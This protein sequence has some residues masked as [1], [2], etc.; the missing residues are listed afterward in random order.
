MLPCPISCSIHPWMRA[1][2]VLRASPYMA[3]TDS[4]GRFQIRNLPV[5][6]HTFRVWHE[7]VGYVRD[8]A[9]G[10]F[11]TD[12]RGRLVVKV[13]EGVKVFPTVELAPA[14]FADKK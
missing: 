4:D 1:W 2:L 14:M 10:E 12:A 6:E 11:V 7:R 5:G 13:D 8:V 3:K 9:A